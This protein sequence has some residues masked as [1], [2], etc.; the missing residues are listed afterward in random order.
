MLKT[1]LAVQLKHLSWYLVSGCLQHMMEK[2]H[3]FQSLELK[4]GNV[5][6]FKGDKKGKIIGSGTVAVSQKDGYIFL[7][8]GR[9][10]TLITSGFLIL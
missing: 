10:T 7:M 4:P 2:R 9:E 5:I 6:G 1:S 3:M 8:K